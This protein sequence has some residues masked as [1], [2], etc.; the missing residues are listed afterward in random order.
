MRLFKNL[1]T[2]SLIIS[3]LAFIG[4]GDE[5]ACTTTCDERIENLNDSCECESKFNENQ[6][7][8][9]DNITSNTTWTADNEYLLTGRI[10]IES[11]ATLTIEPGTVI[12][13][14]QGA[15]ENA[16]ALIVARGG[17]IMAEGTAAN[18]IIFTTYADQIT[19]GEL[20]SPNLTDNINGLWG[21]LIVLGYAPISADASSVQIEGIP[22]S[23]QNGLYG[24]TDPA[25]NSGVL[26][27]ISIRHGGTDI[28]EGNEINGL[29][30]GGVGNGTVIDHIEV[31][32]NVDDGIEFFG[33][34][35][36]ASNCLVWGQ[37]DDAFDCDQAWSGTLDGFVYIAGANSDH[38]LELDG[39]E[40]DLEGTFTLRN[41]VLKGAVGEYCDLRSDVRC[42]IE[43]V[44][45]FNFSSSSDFEF[46]NNKVSQNYLDDKISL[47][48]LTFNTSQLTEGN[49]TIAQIFAEKVATDDNDVAIEQTLGIF[50]TKPLDASIR[51][52]TSNTTGYDVGTFRGWTMA[53]ARGQLSDF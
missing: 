9:T 44:H 19:T 25:D 51:L 7:A 14:L 39:P 10:I 49:T 13:G 41:G 27:Y 28:G 5:E 33:G 43:N 48:G 47:S 53:D 32:S 18:P 40:G 24:G 11:G 29:T 12:K 16:T 45:F 35:V 52:A 22:P 37:G 1:L 46:D 8:L 31:V 4:C 21:G 17:K 15:N 23:D 50:T 20:V 34:T 26:K 2:L 38:A 30:L 3:S 36:N 6:V 42:T